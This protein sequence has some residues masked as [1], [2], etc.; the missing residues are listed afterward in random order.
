MP[1]VIL[2]SRSSRAREGGEGDE[3]GAPSQRRRRCQALSATT[4]QLAA[5]RPMLKRKSPPL[6]ARVRM[7]KVTN[8]ERTSHGPV[9]EGINFGADRTI[10]LYHRD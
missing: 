4:A 7:V 8:A 5:T 3:R 10:R 9:A 2:I 6:L 1:S